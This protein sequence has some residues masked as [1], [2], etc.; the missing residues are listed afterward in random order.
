MT[1]KNVEN[2]V[3]NYPAIV[4]EDGRD[5]AKAAWAEATKFCERRILKQFPTLAECNK[6]VQSMLWRDGLEVSSMA[7]TEF[8]YSFIYKKIAE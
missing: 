3:R 7:I 2:F 5:L 6:E 4:T 8:V 1:A